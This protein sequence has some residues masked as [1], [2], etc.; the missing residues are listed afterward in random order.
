MKLSVTAL[1]IASALLWG[2]A[3]LGTGLANLVSPAYAHDFL[4]TMASLYPG[5]EGAPRLGQVIIGTLYG[6]LDA[7]VA[8]A[9]FAWLYNAFAG[10][11]GPASGPA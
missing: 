10:D 7:A 4:Q 2:I 5:Y 6:V 11:R 8:G 3:M 9:L 1:A